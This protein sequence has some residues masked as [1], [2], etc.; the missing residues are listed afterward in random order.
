MKE[1]GNTS[2]QTSGQK[3]LLTMTGI[4][5]F[6]ALMIV[7]SYQG[8][9]PRI[10]QLK[11]EALEKAIFKVVPGM[12]SKRTFR[13]ESDG[14]FTEVSGKEKDARL[15]YAGYDK[16]GKLVGVAVEAAGMGF[17]DVIK[18][19]YGYDPEKEAVVGFYVLESKETPGLGDKIE[20]DPNFL[21]NFEALDVSLTEDKS[22]TKNTVVAVK[23]GEKKNNWEVDGITGATISSRAIGNLLGTS[24][25]E[26]APVL[27]KNK[28][29]FEVKKGQ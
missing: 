19:I 15:V 28:A 29:F 23:H 10:E 24:T 27:H 5:V 22:K 16:E 20:K 21:A 4:G 25:A 14:S 12:E 11:A 7:L 2:G 3:M 17:A 8:T 18:V 9:L 26:M 6:C 1:A 13:M